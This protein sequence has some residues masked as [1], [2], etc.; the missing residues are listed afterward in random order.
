MI[1]T[2][3]MQGKPDISLVV[4]VSVAPQYVVDLP[5]MRPIYGK[6]SIALN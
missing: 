3:V 2:W 4:I 5:I 6:G 1:L